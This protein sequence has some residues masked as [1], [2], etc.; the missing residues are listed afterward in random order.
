M[1][2]LIGLISLFLDFDQAEMSFGW[3]MRQSSGMSSSIEGM[4][5]AYC[6]SM[7]FKVKARATRDP[8]VRCSEHGWSGYVS[9]RRTQG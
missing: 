4:E 5:K 7:D 1:A 6:G 9:R 2:P 3:Y 8:S